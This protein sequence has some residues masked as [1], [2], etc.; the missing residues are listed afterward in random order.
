MFKYA[1]MVETDLMDALKD[2]PPLDVET[3]ADMMR[4]PACLRDISQAL[5]EFG[6]DYSV[7]GSPSGSYY[8]N[9][10]RAEEAV[11]RSCGRH[12]L[13]AAADRR[14]KRQDDK[15]ADSFFQTVSHGNLPF[16]DPEEDA[17]D[18][19]DGPIRILTYP[20]GA[21]QFLLDDEPVAAVERKEDP[22]KTF[23]VE[24]G[25]YP[26]EFHISCSAKLSE[27]TRRMILCVPF[28]GLYG[29]NP[30]HR[31]NKK[32]DGPSL[33]FGLDFGKLDW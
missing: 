22:V 1:D 11:F 30:A 23:S 4:A 6:E 10:A 20:D 28:L 24:R 16:A 3:V 14:K 7:T 17:M 29:K 2:T 32:R 5:F 8:C 19:P 21:F 18:S 26:A 12:S 33:Q 15:K 9:R 25:E 13:S 27:V 31:L